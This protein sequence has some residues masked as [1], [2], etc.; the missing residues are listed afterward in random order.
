MKCDLGIY[1]SR[2]S[3]KRGPQT[4]AVLLGLALKPDN[5]L[6]AA[7]KLNVVAVYQLLCP[8][9]GVCII[10]AGERSEACEMPVLAND[11]GPILYHRVSSRGRN[12]PVRS[13][14]TVGDRTKFRA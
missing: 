6:R 13:F 1:S 5:E 14:A 8:F 3:R 4:E 10:G 9:D 12:S 7:P 2:C 11:V